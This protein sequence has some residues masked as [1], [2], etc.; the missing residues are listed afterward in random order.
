[1]RA[2]ATTAGVKVDEHDIEE[3]LCGDVPGDV[4]HDDGVGVRLV[5]APPRVA[6]AHHGRLL[7]VELRRRRRGRAAW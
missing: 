7:R 2:G 5:H 4:E 3:A 1:M 6:H